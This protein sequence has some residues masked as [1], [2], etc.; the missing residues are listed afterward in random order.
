MKFIPLTQGLFTQV[1]DEDFNDL[2]QFKWHI[3]K[4]PYTYYA[5]RAV[6]SLDKVSKNRQIKLR[7]H[8]V[9]MNPSNEMEVDH[10]DGDGLN[11]QKANLRIC[12]S[13][14]NMYNRLSLIHI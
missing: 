9:I 5:V 4:A 13:S 11:N 1:D 2:N 6:P 12:T 10:R 8:R 3:V 14:Q 7:M